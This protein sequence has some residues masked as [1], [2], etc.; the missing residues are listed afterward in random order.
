[1]SY[2][3]TFEP[4]NFRVHCRA[5]ASLLDAASNGASKAVN[6]ILSII[7]NLVAVL[8]FTAFADGILQWATRLVGFDDVG[9]QFILG[10][11]FIPVSWALG[12]DWEDCEAV[13]YII[14]S[15]TIINEF[16]AYQILGEF[17]KA[18]KISVRI[19]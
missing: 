15:K 6:V 12:V 4:L 1:M 2:N 16:V 19:F 7:A 17:I 10:K 3:S 13:G 18:G 11:V 8:S 5:D 14:G 9:L